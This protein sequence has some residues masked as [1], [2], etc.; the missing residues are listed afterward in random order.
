MNKNKSFNLLLI[1]QSL[2]A[3]GDNATYSV[4][5]GTLLF[6]V[7]SGV[8]SIVQFGVLS[9]VYANCLFL[10]YILFAPI[11]G[12]FSDR[13][14]KRNILIFAN[15]VKALGAVIGFI[16]IFLGKNFLI[17]SYLLMGI[18]AAIYSPAKYGIIP[19][20]R[21]EEELVK[22][23][24]SMEM[25]TI[26]SILT[27]V[28]GGSLFVDHIGP[29]N[30]Y[31]IL[32]IVFLLAIIFNMLIDKSNICDKNEEI[33]K[34]L[35]DF[36]GSLKNII[37]TKLLFIPII[38]TTIFWGASL[39]V[40]LNVQTWGQNTLHLATATK[41]SMLALWLSI[42]IILGSFIAGKKFKTGQIKQSWIFGFL[43]GLMIV[44]T[45][46]KYVNYS[47]IVFELILIGMTG[48]IFLIPLNAEVQAKTGVHSIGKVIAIQNFLEN[49]AM[50]LS[51]GVFWY[52]NKISLSPTKTLFIIGGI[53][54]LLNLFL[55]RP[56]L[57]K[58]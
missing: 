38:G 58:A 25:T 20:M 16:G 34:S 23:N 15:V 2:S 8:I 52:L 53:L 4:I 33:T 9:A 13:F 54:C 41:I 56:L 1:G 7:K 27:G 18:G 11:L 50:L 5:M 37:L 45:A 31:F 28:I 32:F 29:K 35:K 43:M 39:F 42:G 3:F 46:L 21:T 44:L 24:A 17:P 22:A 48:G 57:K 12:W 14:P 49:L 51:A 30:S 40:K 6:S 55:L 36:T 47:L 19:E 10:P 26:F